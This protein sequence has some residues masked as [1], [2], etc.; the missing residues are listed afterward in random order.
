MILKFHD[1][2]CKIILNN[3]VES[4]IFNFDDLHKFTARI[5]C[6]FNIFT[7]SNDFSGH[8]CNV[9]FFISNSKS[10]NRKTPCLSY[11]NVGLSRIK[12]LELV[13]MLNFI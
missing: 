2:F 8:Y 9:F 5:S 12:M 11:E 10:R 6:Y 4:F 3:S 13:S 1:N 7:S